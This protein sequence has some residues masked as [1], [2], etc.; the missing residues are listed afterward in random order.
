MNDHQENIKGAVAS[1]TTVVGGVVAWLPEID[2]MLKIFVEGCGCVGAVYASLYWR[3][4]W[5]TRNHK[6][7]K[8]H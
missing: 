1:V 8:H 7:N 3:H 5:Q 6:K 2:L 4:K